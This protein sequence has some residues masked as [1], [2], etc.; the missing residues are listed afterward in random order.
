MR[1]LSATGSAG[2]APEDRDERLART[3]LERDR[4]RDGA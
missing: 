1:I 3:R 2:N 4:S